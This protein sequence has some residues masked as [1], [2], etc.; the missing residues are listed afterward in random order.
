MHDY[1]TIEARYQLRLP[2]LYRE[3]QAADCFDYTQ[4][5]K[6]IEFTDHQWLSLQSGGL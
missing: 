2:Q 3:L 6:Y 1:D 4:P 5:D